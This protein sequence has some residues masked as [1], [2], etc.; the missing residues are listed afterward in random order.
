MVVPVHP[1]VAPDTGRPLSDGIVDARD[2]DV[3][4]EDG[5][6]M[7][8]VLPTA[9]DVPAGELVTAVVVRRVHVRQDEHAHR[10]IFTCSNSSGAAGR[11]HGSRGGPAM[12]TI[13]AG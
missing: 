1:Q 13:A 12:T 9:H 3:R 7:T 8:T 2:P 5:D 10:R 11:L 4:G 6:R